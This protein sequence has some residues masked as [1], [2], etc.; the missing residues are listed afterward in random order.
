MTKTFCDKCGKEI[1][2]Y[3]DS[4]TLIYK[5]NEAFPTTTTND[6]CIDCWSEFLKWMEKKDR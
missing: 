1:S 5:L 3:R 4:A 2:P 6:L